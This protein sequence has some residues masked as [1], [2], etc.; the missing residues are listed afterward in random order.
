[1]WMSI[2]MFES[3]NVGTVSKASQELDRLFLVSGRFKQWLLTAR[4][5]SDTVY[6]A[7][8]F[9]LQQIAVVSSSPKQASH[10]WR[11]IMGKYS[12]VVGFSHWPWVCCLLL[13]RN[14]DTPPVVEKSDKLMLL[15]LRDSNPVVATLALYF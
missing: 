6:G 5:L 15:S 11:L 1:M 8:S 3:A 10:P 12:R 7:H 2:C 9:F 4:S 14:C 13:P